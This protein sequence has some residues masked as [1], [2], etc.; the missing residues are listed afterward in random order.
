M[1]SYR[2]AKQNVDKILGLAPEKQ[3]QNTEQKPVR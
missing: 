1:I 3:K 2:T